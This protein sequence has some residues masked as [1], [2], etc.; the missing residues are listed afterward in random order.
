MQNVVPF[1]RFVLRLALVACVRSRLLG[2]VRSYPPRRLA[3]AE[4]ANR[5]PSVLVFQVDAARLAMQQIVQEKQLV[6]IITSY[7]HDAVTT[8]PVAPGGVV[9]LAHACSMSPTVL[10]VARRRVFEPENCQLLTRLLLEQYRHV[11]GRVLFVRARPP[12]RDDVEVIAHDSEGL[13]ER[14]KR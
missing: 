6:C 12:P 4:K 9:A 2:R 1:D 7:P 10:E 3:A 13:D 14:K 11:D 8:R 5:N